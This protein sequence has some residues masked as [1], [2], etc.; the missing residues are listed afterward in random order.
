MPLLSVIWIIHGA[1]C[2]FFF[3]YGFWRDVKNHLR[4]LHINFYIK[5]A[6]KRNILDV[7]VCFILIILLYFKLSN[8]FL[9][10][11]ALETPYR[12]QSRDT[13]Q[14]TAA[15]YKNKYVRNTWFKNQSFLGRY[16]LSSKDKLVFY[17]TW[18]WLTNVSYA[19]MYIPQICQRWL[20]LLLTIDLLQILVRRILSL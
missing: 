1:S 6:I 12:N 8:K 19:H 10:D 9:L 18:E 15:D 13:Q 5:I 17:F 14:S 20:Y 7:F 3:L 16:Y 4:R 11:R 2:E